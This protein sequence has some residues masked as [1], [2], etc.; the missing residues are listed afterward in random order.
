E[1]VSYREVQTPRG[2]RSLTVLDDGTQVWLNANSTL[3]FATDFVAGNTREVFL[4]GEAFFD[5]VEDKSKPFIVHASGVSVEVLGTAF[6]VLSYDD[7]GVVETTLV[8]GKIDIVPNG[9]DSNSHLTL[10]PNQRAV[11]NRE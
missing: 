7:D 1:D 11:F 4:D 3:R 2:D 6:N 10:L 8:R 9:G 5:V